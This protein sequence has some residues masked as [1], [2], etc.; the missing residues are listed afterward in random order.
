MAKLDI[1]RLY[2]EIT[3]N[4][5][6]ECA[7]CFRGDRENKNMPLD[8]LVKIF[9][10]VR[11][12][13][14]LLLSGGEPLLAVD[15]LKKIAELMKTRNIKIDQIKIVTNG[16]VL[17][18]ELLSVLKY[19]DEVSR[20][21]L[22]VSEDKF[23]L[24]ELEKKGLLEIRDTNVEMLRQVFRINE[25]KPDRYPHRIQR[26]GRALDLTDEMLSEINYSGDVE[27]KYFLGSEA[28]LEK[29]RSKYG[30]PTV[31]D[32]HILNYLCIDAYGNIVPVYYSYVEEDKLSYANLYRNKSLLDTVY[33]VKAKRNGKLN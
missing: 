18:P 29:S 7:H 26:M 17:S 1:E 20:L 13:R 21:E 32:N 33:K 8:V 9:R 6:L 31:W 28:D 24:M 23:H 16:T 22:A 3:R 27:T 19:F 25:F 10:D 4:C 15:Q 5:T 30:L 12:I 11:H 14:I 2:L